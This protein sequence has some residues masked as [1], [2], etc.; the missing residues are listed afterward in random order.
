MPLRDQSETYTIYSRRCDIHIVKVSDWNSNRRG[1][2]RI[3]VE[4]VLGPLI[5]IKITQNPAKL[6][7]HPSIGEAVLRRLRQITE[8]IDFYHIS[9]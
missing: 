7:G 2:G 9:S 8:S 4:M 6:L 3:W 1:A 5:L